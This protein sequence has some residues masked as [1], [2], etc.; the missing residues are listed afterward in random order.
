MP[1][2]VRTF[3][4]S[5]AP[6]VL[7]PPY[8]EFNS[9]DAF[10]QLTTVSGGMES[11]AVSPDQAR[12]RGSLS[13]MGWALVAQPVSASLFDAMLGRSLFPA[14][15]DKGYMDDERRRGGQLDAKLT[16]AFE[17]TPLEDGINHPAEQIIDKALASGEGRHVLEQFGQFAIDARRPEFAASVLR[18]LGRQRP[19]TAAWR[20]GVVRSA[21]AAND[22]R[23]R[24][25]AAQAAESWGGPEVRQALRNHHETVPWLR[26]Y[27][28]DILED[29][30][31]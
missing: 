5:T 1:I 31:A 18:C 15:V 2:D 29:F 14:L 10:R 4:A 20:A 12:F 6:P 9:S 28:A 22:V 16:R 17:D 26:A 25:A 23:V 7:L 27:I 21:L 19:G 3:A 24:D 11:F 13:E 30:E 8:V